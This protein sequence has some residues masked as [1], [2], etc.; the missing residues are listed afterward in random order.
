[1]GDVDADAVASGVPEV[2]EETERV[3]V[4]DGVPD[5]EGVPLDVP[6]KEGVNEGEVVGVDPPAVGEPEGVPDF[7]VVALG[8]GV[9]EVV[10][11]GEG[12]STPITNSGPAYIVPALVTLFHAFVVKVPAVAPVHTLTRER[13]P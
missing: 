7:E 3:P 4:S 13:M 11:E 1:M 6:D 10:G 8:D 2:E 5:F 12:N 9:T